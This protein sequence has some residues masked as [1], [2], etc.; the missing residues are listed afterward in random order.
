M[1]NKITIRNA[2][3][4]PRTANFT[5]IPRGQF[6]K[7]GDRHFLVRLDPELAAGLEAQGWNVKWTKAKPDHPEWEPYPFLKVKINYNRRKK[8][9]IYMVTKRGNTLLTEETVGQLEG[10]Y[11]EK[12]DLTLTNVYYS[13]YNQYSIVLDTGFFTIE[14]NELYDEY[15]GGHVEPAM[16]DE[17]D[18]PFM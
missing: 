11:F 4:D 3:V 9:A 1:E 16:D 18:N 17:D 8:P 6:D 5:G 15:F 14:P 13:T 7:E 2:Q 12:V 10:C